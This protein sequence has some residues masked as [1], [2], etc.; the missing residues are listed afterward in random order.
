MAYRVV[1]NAH[2]QHSE[3]VGNEHTLARYWARLWGMH[4]HVRLSVWGM[5]THAHSRVK[6]WHTHTEGRESGECTHTHTAGQ[7]WGNVHTAHTAGRESGGNAVPGRI[8][9]HV[10]PPPPLG[11]AASSHSRTH[12]LGSRVLTCLPPSFSPLDTPT[13]STMGSWRLR[14]PQHSQLLTIL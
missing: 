4:T 10:C 5:H 1:R 9:V 6:V 11:A 14:S 12:L 13:S 7:Q 3:S 8:R 2:R